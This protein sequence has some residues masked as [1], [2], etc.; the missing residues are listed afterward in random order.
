MT[1]FYFTGTGNSLFAARKIEEA[2]GAKLISIPQAIGSQ[3]SNILSSKEALFDVHQQALASEETLSSWQGLRDARISQEGPVHGHI[4]H[5]GWESKGSGL[6]QEMDLIG[7][8]Q[9]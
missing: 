8:Q 9:A 7:R 3:Q 6:F 5:S 1:I 2:T 4:W